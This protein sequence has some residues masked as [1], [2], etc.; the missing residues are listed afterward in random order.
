MIKI[1]IVEDSSF[2]RMNLKKILSKHKELD[3]QFIARN[4]VEALKILEHNEVDVVLLDLFMPKMD[5]IETL[6]NIMNSKPIPTLVFTA[7]NKKDNAEI[8][9]KALRLGA[10]D[11]VQKP[12]GIGSKSLEK[13]IQMLVK[14]IIAVHNSRDKLKVFINKAEISNRLQKS[15]K[16]NKNKRPKRKKPAAPVKKE[17]KKAKKRKYNIDLSKKINLSSIFIIGASTGGPPLLLNFLK[18][19]TFN[20]QK[21]GIIVQ[22]I[23]DG[24]TKF[25]AKRL[26]SICEFKVLEAKH[27]D[28]LKPGKIYIT[29]GDY[30]LKL[31][32]DKGHI[33][34]DI[35]QE[36]RV[37]GVRPC[38]DYTLVTGAQILKNKLLAII[39]TGMGRDGTFGFR[40]VKEYGGTTIAQDPKEAMIDSM[41]LNAIRSGNVDYVMKVN[42]IKHH[43][44][45][46][47]VI[48][49]NARG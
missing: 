40:I 44:N 28:M 16:S 37:W 8:L 26:D 42:D 4:G 7:A 19:L 45:S 48:K 13:V 32:E 11:I 35:T 36:D 2:M 3:I 10:M 29:P 38:I 6:E 30:H 22:H 23:P 41:P 27:G 33:Y 34:F 17:I 9:L 46:N 39:F 24:F 14:K 25:F 12:K 18:D 47:T 20:P 21:S 31:Y 1:L 15:R 5:G 49:Q 43:L